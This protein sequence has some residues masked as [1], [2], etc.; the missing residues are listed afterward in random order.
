MPAQ[1]T[2]SNYP[3]KNVLGWEPAWGCGQLTRIRE[4]VKGGERRCAHYFVTQDGLKRRGALEL[5]SEGIT[6]LWGKVTGGDCSFGPVW[7]SVRGTGYRISGG[8]LGRGRVDIGVNIICPRGWVDLSWNFG[9]GKVG[10]DVGGRRRGGTTPS[11]ATFVRVGKGNRAPR[12][13]NP[14]TWNPQA[15]SFVKAEDEGDRYLS[16]GSANC[17]QAGI[18]ARRSSGTGLLGV[19]LGLPGRGRA[20]RHLRCAGTKWTS[21]RV[22]SM[23]TTATPCRRSPYSRPAWTLNL[24]YGGRGGRIARELL[25]R[26]TSGPTTQG[27]RNSWAGN[28]SKA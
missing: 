12:F 16:T 10:Q 23:T 20:E 14:E 6:C 15:R 27:G 3:L 26:L 25:P 17:A 22:D 8:I 5:R 13:T 21:R 7:T 4:D 24:F 19:V 11:G 18:L 28:P 2:G 9:R 1:N